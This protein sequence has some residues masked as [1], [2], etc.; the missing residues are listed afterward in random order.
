VDCC[1]DRPIFTNHSSNY[2]EPKTWSLEYGIALVSPWMSGSV[3]VTHKKYIIGVSAEYCSLGLKTFQALLH[4][5]Y[6]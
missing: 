3:F 5:T 2:E 1:N 6:I 4:F